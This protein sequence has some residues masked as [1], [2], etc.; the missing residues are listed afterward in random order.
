MVVLASDDHGVRMVFEGGRI[1]SRTA[2]AVMQP[3]PP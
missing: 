2:F 1:M 3:R